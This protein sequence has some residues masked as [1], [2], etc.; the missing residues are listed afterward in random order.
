MGNAR[1][2]YTHIQTTNMHTG[3]RAQIQHTYTVA[4]KSQLSAKVHTVQSTNVCPLPASFTDKKIK[5]KTANS[6]GKIQ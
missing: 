6:G 2:I 4:N 5:I 1:H 3:A